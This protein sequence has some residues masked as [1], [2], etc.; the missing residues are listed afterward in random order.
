MKAAALP[1]QEEPTLKNI[2]KVV[3]ELEKCRLEE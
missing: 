3:R 2:A 1:R